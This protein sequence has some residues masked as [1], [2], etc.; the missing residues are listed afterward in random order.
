MHDTSNLEGTEFFHQIFSGNLLYMWQ[1]ELLF[2]QPDK[3]LEY[4]LVLPYF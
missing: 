4:P 2:K 3:L 1:C